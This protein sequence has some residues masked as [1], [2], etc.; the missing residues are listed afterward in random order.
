MM[1]DTQP[2][3]DFFH[4]GSEAFFRQYDGDPNFQERLAVWTGYIDRYAPQG[5]T[6]LDVGCGPGVLSLYAASRGLRVTGLDP[7]ENMLRICRRSQAERGLATASFLQA[8]FES[9]P[10]LGL[11]ADLVL[12]SSVLEY[13]DAPEAALSILAGAMT[14]AGAMVVSLPNAASI[15][16]KLDLLTYRLF[17]R[18]KY[19]R[20]VRT[21]TTPEALAVLAAKVGL[22]VVDTAFYAGHHRLDRLLAGLPPRRTARLFACVL[23]KMAA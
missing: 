19:Y 6:V 7:A 9:L 15:H 23:R 22:E 14:E 16:R 5:G 4:R 2:V 10:S 3:K 17:G 1:S 13:F 8:G 12:C 11:R 20:L 21:I 18:P